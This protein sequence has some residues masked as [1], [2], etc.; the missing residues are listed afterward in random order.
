[1]TNAPA[2]APAP[3]V[4]ERPYRGI[5]PFRYIDQRIFAA[6]AEET[7]ELLSSVLI[8]RGVLLY[9]DS[10]AGKSS[11]VNA[12][13]VAAVRPEEFRPE[14]LRVQPL[15]GREFKVER[16]PERFADRPPFLPSNF[17][18]PGSEEDQ[19]L[20]FELSA[21]ELYAPLKRRADEQAERERAARERGEEAPPRPPVPLLILDQFEEFI[22]LFEEAAR[23]GE[24]EAAER[25]RREAPEARRRILD[26]LSRLLED[27]APPVKLLFVFREDYLA[28]LSPLFG[29]RP[30]LLDQYV[31]LLPPPVGQAAEIIRAPFAD[32]SLR[33]RFLAAAG[34]APRSGEITPGL[35]EEIAA[36][37]AR[38]GEGDF[39]NLSELQIVCLKLCESAD[40]ETFYRR[41]AGGQVEN[42]LGQYW[43]DTFESMPASL[44]DP[45]LALLGH[46]VTASNTR[47]IVTE[48]DLHRRE[49]KNFPRPLVEKA[50]SAL[51]EQRLVRREPRH[52]IY[53]YEIT[54]EFLVP[55]IQRKTAERAAKAEAERVAEAA[56]RQLARERTKQ[57]RLRWLGV[58]L[59]VLVL[60]GF[61]LYLYTSVLKAEAE[62]A[63]KTAE[64]E[65]EGYK[66]QQEQFKGVLTGIAALS[67]P[68]AG[69]RARAVKDLTEMTRRSQHIGQ[70]SE[71]VVAAIYPLIAKDKSP[72]VAA[73]AAD[74]LPAATRGANERQ[75]DAILEAASQNAAIARKL[76]PRAY[77]KLADASQ[78]P[79]AEK[80]ADALKQMG[81]AIPPMQVASRASAD[82]LR[83]SEPTGG[84]DPQ[85]V[86]RVIEAADG[87][88]WKEPRLI[89]SDTARPGHFE[90]WFTADAPA[91]ESS[92]Q[93]PPISE[94][95]N[96]STGQPDA[97]NGEVVFNIVNQSGEALPASIGLSAT[98][99]GQVG[100]N[101]ELINRS[102]P[103]APGVYNARVN[104][105]GYAVENFRVEVRAGKRTERRVVMRRATPKEERQKQ[106][107][108][109]RSWPPPVSPRQTPQR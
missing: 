80:I 31:R 44:H 58:G 98:R 81:F 65:R 67:E 97:A 82:E 99:P 6:R 96:P 25:A 63:R 73:A 93:R 35:A 30:E 15:L 94:F 22:T 100:V 104:V 91:P 34:G 85:A 53:F 33:E 86:L 18:A 11:L 49:E 32:E 26:T 56:E 48:D 29:L 66:R 107:E 8:Y 52:K 78:R 64:L 12:G 2:A 14:R 95:I 90:V 36:Q 106:A 51:V 101:I 59:G 92:P 77:I 102:G 3:P 4:P 37:L 89:S 105:P 9:G 19:A 5:E 1:M 17:V 23:G 88:P 39:L 69:T 60:V 21:E 7:W 79:R 46:M 54:S 40:P 62:T 71:Q 47:N 50:L 83:Y 108:R 87:R 84:A 41:E 28:K 16:I 75:T 76:P 55:W 61:A 74:L 13:L 43:S 103:L 45:A 109:E 38:R 42:I 27:G 72:E 10:G 68:D 20:S 70:L 57:R 24:T